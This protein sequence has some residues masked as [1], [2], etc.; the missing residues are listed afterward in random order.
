GEYVPSS[1]QSSPNVSNMNFTAL[2]VAC[3][4]DSAIIN[5]LSS[6]SSS[7]SKLLQTLTSYN[8]AYLLCTPGIMIYSPLKFL[9]V[10]YIDFYQTYRYVLY[11]VIN[12]SVLVT[13][14]KL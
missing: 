3:S 7:Y 4:S 8:L 2:I 14:H 12:T 6:R 1:S 11:L 9:V 10:Y 5:L 13:T